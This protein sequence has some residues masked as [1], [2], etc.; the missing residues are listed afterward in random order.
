MVTEVD[1]K[2]LAEQAIETALVLMRA[3]GRFEWVSYTKG[4]PHCDP[5]WI[6]DALMDERE[7]LQDLFTLARDTIKGV[8]CDCGTDEPCSRCSALACCDAA[9]GIPEAQQAG[10]GEVG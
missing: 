8:E 6:I 2:A 4:M 10:A 5:E 3:K 1:V 9:L 7:R